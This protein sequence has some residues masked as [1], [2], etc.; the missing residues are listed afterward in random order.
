MIWDI[1]DI[2]T[3]PKPNPAAAMPVMS[4]FLSGN[5]LTDEVSETQYPNPVPIPP[6]TPTPI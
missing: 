6:I 3:A 1:S 2:N 5:D 4:P